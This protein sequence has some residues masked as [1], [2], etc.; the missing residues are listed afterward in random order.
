MVTAMR[1]NVQSVLPLRLNSKFASNPFYP[2]IVGDLPV[3]F[4]LAEGDIC[5]QWPLKEL[6]LKV[7]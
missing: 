7:I 6:L 5:A 1:A 4:M 2:L 3:G